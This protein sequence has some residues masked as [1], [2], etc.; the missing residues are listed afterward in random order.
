MGVL[1]RGVGSLRDKGDMLALIYSITE[2][3]RVSSNYW[4]IV[5]SMDAMVW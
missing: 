2:K 5:V 4:V 1:K 3:Y